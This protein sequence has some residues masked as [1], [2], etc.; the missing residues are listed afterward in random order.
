MAAVSSLTDVLAPAHT[1]GA[2]LEKVVSMLFAAFNLYTGD[3]A[4]LRAQLLVWTEEL[5][6]FPL[7]AIRKAYRWAI[8]GEGKIP[9]LASFI[10]DVKVAIGT[11]VLA[12]RRLLQNWLQF[13][14]D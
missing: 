7:Y 1:E 8:R 6:E 4:K 2:E 9:S 12:R 5:E 13:S 10:R 11:N 14:D 3:Q